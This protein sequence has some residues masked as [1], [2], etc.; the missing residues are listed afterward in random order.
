MKRKIPHLNLKNSNVESVNKDKFLKTKTKSTRKVNNKNSTVSKNLSK[1][2]EN[3]KSERKDLK[4][5][6]E[7]MVE[8]A[9]KRENEISENTNLNLSTSIPLSNEEIFNEILNKMNSFQQVINFHEELNNQYVNE[10]QEFINYFM[11]YFNEFTRNEDL[12]FVQFKEF[13]LKAEEIILNKL[14]FISE[15]NSDENLKNSLISFFDNCENSLHLMNKNSNKNDYENVVGVS[16][17]VSNNNNNQTH[18]SDLFLI[19]SKIKNFA[20]ML[21][22]KINAKDFSLDSVNLKKMNQDINQLNYID[23]TT[24]TNH[25][26]D[27]NQINLNIPNHNHKENLCNHTEEKSDNNYHSNFSRLARNKLKNSERKRMRLLETVK[28]KKSRKRYGEGDLLSTDKKLNN[29]EKFKDAYYGGKN[30]ELKKIVEKS[31][32]IFLRNF[33]QI[34]L[35]KENGLFSESYFSKVDRNCL[36]AYKNFKYYEVKIYFSIS[37]ETSDIERYI[38]KIRKLFTCHIMTYKTI[39]YNPQKKIRFLKISISGVGKKQSLMKR[40]LINFMSEEVKLNCLI[41]ISLFSNVF[42]CM[43]K[44]LNEKL[45]R[46]RKSEE[47]NGIDIGIDGGEENFFY[48]TNVKETLLNKIISRIKN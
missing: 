35:I 25:I 12:A 43:T 31:K 7:G 40:S 37:E 11:N 4:K 32:K 1:R 13:F 39:D 23:H 48:Y 15:I 41:K 20:I 27:T 46:G 44:S 29:S 9:E 33:L 3:V 18:P 47:G 10:V 22:E 19:F 28:I 5:I 34:Y 21:K 14:N 38:L 17:S 26:N 42:D 8:N 16:T 6:F 36:S 24:D 30:S 2:F 45:K